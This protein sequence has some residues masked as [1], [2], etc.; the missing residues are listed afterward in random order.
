MVNSG[1]AIV[2]I[3]NFI[4]ANICIIAAMM[5]TVW[6]CIKKTLLNE[7]AKQNAT[8]AAINNFKI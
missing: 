4:K 7:I 1:V 8:I 3:K 2:L 6:P 5:M